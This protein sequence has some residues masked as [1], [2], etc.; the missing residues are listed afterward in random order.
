MNRKGRSLAT[1]KR[2]TKRASSACENGLGGCKLATRPA[3]AERSHD[4]ENSKHSRSAEKNARMMA[5]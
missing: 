1:K 2:A 4:E 3:V 5:V